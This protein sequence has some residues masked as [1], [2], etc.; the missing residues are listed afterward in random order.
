MVWIHEEEIWGDS[1]N[2]KRLINWVLTHNLRKLRSASKNLGRKQKWK[3]WLG[4][5]RLPVQRSVGQ[6]LQNWWKRKAIIFK[7]CSS[8]MCLACSGRRCPREHTSLRMK[9]YFPGLKLL[10]D[11]VSYWLQCFR[12]FEVEAHTYVPFWWH[13]LGFWRFLP[14]LWRSTWPRT[15]WNWKLFKISWPWPWISFHQREGPASQHY[16]FYPLCGPWSDSKFQ[17]VLHQEIF[18]QMSWSTIRWHWNNFEG[19]WGRHNLTFWRL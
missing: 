8:L 5:G 17:V 19:I 13:L 10:K 7:K 18:L 6:H 1:E 3:V 9:L 15:R 16:I 4:L 2:W 14:P 12:R 11:G